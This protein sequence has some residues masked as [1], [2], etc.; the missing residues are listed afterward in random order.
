[1][2]IADY[3]LLEPAFG[4]LANCF[5][6]PFLAEQFQSFRLQTGLREEK[7][8]H[9]LIS[10]VYT[11]ADGFRILRRSGIKGHQFLGQIMLFR[12]LEANIL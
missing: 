1:V 2:W 5:V 6:R 11:P 7:F 3:L 9:I 10:L 4:V 8:V 12:R